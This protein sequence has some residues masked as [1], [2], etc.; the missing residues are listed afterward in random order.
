MR[1][2]LRLV[3]FCH[4]FWLVVG[5][6]FV[7]IDAGFTAFESHFVRFLG[8]WFLNFFVHGLQSVAVAAL[9]GVGRFHPRPLVAGQF[10]AFGFE[11]LFGVDGAQYFSKHF[12]GRLD[13]ANH[14]RPP[15][16]GDVAIRAGGPHTGAIGVVN[17]LFVLGVHVVT[18]F[19]ATDTKSFVIGRFKSGVEPTPEHNAGHKA[20]NQQCKQGV[21]A[22]GTQ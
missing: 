17:G 20:N 18:H 22:G 4:A 21:F 12:I 15:L 3:G 1:A 5:D 8:A 11:F 2:A 6:A 10:K 16:F 19:M 9:N 7:A 13:F 14:L